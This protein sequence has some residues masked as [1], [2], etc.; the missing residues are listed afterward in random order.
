VTVLSRRAGLPSSLPT[1]TIAVWCPDWPVV[2][3]MATAGAPPDAP[4]AVL[5]GGVVLACSPAA[6]DAG[7]RRGLRRREAQYRCPDLLV[8]PRDHVGEAR[9][10]EPLVVAVEAAVPGVEV[11]RPG[12]C[13]LAARGPARFFGGEKVTAVHL[14]GLADAAMV[15]GGVP[16]A[17]FQAGVAE[18]SFAAV[19]AARRDE[20]VPAGQTP[21]FLAPYH[22]QVLDRPELA[23]LLLRLGLRTLGAFA[24]LSAGDVTARFGADGALAHRLACGLE[25][26]PPAVRAPA[27]DLVTST[28]F[29]PP[30]THVEQAAFVTKTLA[31]HLHARLVELGLGCTRLGIEVETSRGEERVRLWRH[32]GVLTASDIAERVRWQLDGWLSGRGDDRPTAGI[33]RLRLVPDQ[34]LPHGGHQLGLWGEVGEDDARAAR[35]L[36]RVQGMLGHPAVVTAVVGTGRGPAD[37]VRLVPWGESRDTGDPENPAGA[38]GRRSTGE[39][40]STGAPW[41]GQLPAPNPATVPERPL[42]AVVVDAVG[43]AVTVSG[44][45]VVSAP[46]A[47]LAVAEGREQPVIAWA[48]PWP[49][50]ERW[51]D[52]DNARRR[53]RFQLVTADGAAWLLAL[54]SG[55]WWVEGIYD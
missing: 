52:P 35:A 51:W 49:A 7:V 34:V 29:D 20:V 46:P 3:A 17:G 39:P 15:E 1:R 16:G 45:A 44:R 25:L 8:L 5:A 13:V 43:A 36:T 27:P 32:E 54:E 48:G 2:T 31:E 28:E 40:E 21:P 12:L 4:A 53:A 22:V 18:G 30:A 14:A 47:R 37:R 24:E 23:D 10:F 42:P 19:L 26:H 50:D 11:V 41:P 33:V 55:R 38:R 6:R 9:A